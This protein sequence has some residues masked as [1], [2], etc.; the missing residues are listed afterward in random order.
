MNMLDRLERSSKIALIQGKKKISFA[1]LLE[2]GL[3]FGSD[4]GEQGINKADYILIFIPLSISLYQ[5]FIG[6]WAIGAVPIF[7]DFSRGV[8]FVNDAI[9]RLQPKAMICDHVTGLV[10]LKYPALRKVK[11]LKVSE[12]GDEITHLD[13]DNE[14]PAVLTFTSGTTGTPKVVIRSHGFLM[15]QYDVLSKHADFSSDHKD[16]GTLAIFTVANLLSNITTVLPKKRYKTKVIPKELAKS[17]EKE[18]IN[19]LIGSPKLIADLLQYSHLPMVKVIYL[20]GAPVYPSV[21]EKVPKHIALHIVY[22][23]TEAEPIAHIR[24]SEVGEAM[25]K[26]IKL[27]HGLP[28]GRVIPEVECMIGEESEILV[29]GAIVLA[30][31]GVGAWHPTGDTGFF[32]E[33]GLLWLTGRVSQTIKDR[34]GILHPFAVECVLDDHFGIRGAVLNVSD[35]RVVVIEENGPTEKQILSALAAFKIERVV[36]VENLPMDKRHGAKI[37]YNHVREMMTNEPFYSQ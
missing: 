3:R 28:V 15:D 19:R 33:D 7:I 13:L 10:R 34:H 6:T 25:L 23:S 14:H 27:G 24:W 8:D 1:D 26:K 21:A 37:N 30:K 36:I 4:M 9:V 11:V 31:D 20:G 16:L 12:K 5:T 29:R 2:Q 18:G 22:G 35:S 32:D 17:I